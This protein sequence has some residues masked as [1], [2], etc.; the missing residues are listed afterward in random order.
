ML[1]GKQTSSSCL[2]LLY[3][4]A[5]I[6][7]FVSQPSQASITHPPPKLTSI[8]AL[9]E[10]PG[11][12]SIPSIYTFLTDPN[13]QALSDTKESIP[14]IDFSLLTSSIPDE[15]SK[16]IQELGKACQDWGFF[17]VYICSM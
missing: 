15:R 12:S 3:S 8:K 13:D 11:L 16:M 4:M 9:A 2:C 6:S 10:S 5:A 1:M 14:I 7:P 17:M